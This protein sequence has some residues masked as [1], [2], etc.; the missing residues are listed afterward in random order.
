[1]NIGAGMD[2]I[3]LYLNDSDEDVETGESQHTG[4]QTQKT[5]ASFSN[6]N[7]ASLGAASSLSTTSMLIY[8]GNSATIPN[9]ALGSTHAEDMEATPTKVSVVTFFSHLISI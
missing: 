1:M 9:L 7:D 3:L 4:S 2:L 5:S 8:H 6:N